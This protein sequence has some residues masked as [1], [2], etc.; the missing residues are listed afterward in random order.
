M[1]SPFLESPRQISR[2]E[3]EEVVTIVEIAYREASKDLFKVPCAH[4]H[5]GSEPNPD[6]FHLA[7]QNERVVCSGNSICFVIFPRQ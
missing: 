4:R 7:K 5:G 3:I 6:E 1:Q 2:I